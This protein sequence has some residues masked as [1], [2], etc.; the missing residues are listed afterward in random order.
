MS[1]YFLKHHRFFYPLIVNSTDAYN[2]AVCKI[3]LYKSIHLGNAHG[4]AYC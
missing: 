3:E 2:L 4:L 1:A